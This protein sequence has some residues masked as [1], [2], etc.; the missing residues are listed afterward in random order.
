MHLPGHHED[1]KG[2]RCHISSGAA[3]K[4]RDEWWA[5]EHLPSGHEKYETESVF[6]DEETA[7]G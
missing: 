7:F 5:E 3:T 4:H 2:L 6:A 1:F